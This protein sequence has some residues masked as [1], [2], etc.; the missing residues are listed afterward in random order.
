[1]KP[2]VRKSG[3]DWIVVHYGIEHSRHTSL[4]LAME[5]AEWV[6]RRQERVRR[7]CL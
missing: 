7:V 2:K 4:A 1:M 5:C 6:A 3:H